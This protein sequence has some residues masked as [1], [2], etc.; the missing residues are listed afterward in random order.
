MLFKQ[1]E[2]LQQLDRL[3]KKQCT[4]SASELAEKLNLSRR[5]VYNY[6]EELKLLGIPIAYNR[7]IQSFE[8]ENNCKL[9]LS[10]SVK[11]LTEEE[12]KILVGGL[13]TDFSHLCNEIAQ[14]NNIFD[15][16]NLNSAGISM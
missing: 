16:S 9:E 1:F 2:R 15:I 6:I 12:T 14:T 5:H 3:I 13:K 10:L 11:I 8:Y 4:G 7:N